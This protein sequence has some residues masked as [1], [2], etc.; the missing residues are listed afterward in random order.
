MAG[1]SG[2]LMYFKAHACL[3]AFV[4]I[5]RRNLNTACITSQT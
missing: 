3:S 1:S 2:V 4:N 5:L